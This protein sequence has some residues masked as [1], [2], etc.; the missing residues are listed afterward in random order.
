MNNYKEKS[1]SHSNTS[2]IF[3]KTLLLKNTQILD[4]LQQTNILCDTLIRSQV[5]GESP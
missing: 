4:I 1:V 2:V 3:C 5:I